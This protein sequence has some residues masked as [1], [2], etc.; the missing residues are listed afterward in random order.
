MTDTEKTHPCTLSSKGVA[1][2][3]YC[4]AMNRQTNTHLTCCVKAACTSPWRFCPVCIVERRSPIHT[5]QEGGV[6]RAHGAVGTLNKKEII[7][8]REKVSRVTEEEPKPAIPV[9][10]P[11][12]LVKAKEKSEIQETARRTVHHRVTP[13]SLSRR[14][15]RVME[16]RLN[17]KKRR[18]KHLGKRLTRYRT[19]P[20]KVAFKL[21]STWDYTIA[22]VEH[23]MRDMPKDPP[24]SLWQV[25]HRATEYLNIGPHG[26]YLRLAQ[27]LT[28]TDLEHMGIREKRAPR[29]VLP[30][31]I[32]D[33]DFPRFD[34]EF[35]E[36]CRAA[37]MRMG[38]YRPE[39]PE[40]V[41]RAFT[42][43]PRN[44]WADW[45]TIVD[46]LDVAYALQH[47]CVDGK[48]GVEEVGKFFG[49]Q[50][51]WVE[52]VLKLH[53]L[54]PTIRGFIGPKASPDW[55]LQFGQ[56][57]LVSS[58]KPSE[59]L[60]ATREEMWRVARSKYKL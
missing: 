40:K 56:A 60:S 17:E 45:D 48:M 9:R 50:G 34:R 47:F 32:P 33:F 13:E 18:L 57:V 36:E 35:D 28:D 42:A 41:L 6:C 11:R 59:Q 21:F 30:K 7:S 3:Q 52:I 2:E 5:L 14:L 43:I 39:E 20:E 54:T 29:E 49:R 22:A 58:K 4:R 26:L 53:K 8:R 38:A 10:V 25:A 1:T 46:P 19:T 44:S 23:V 37:L 15:A 27:G 55:R 24:P 31:R 51:Y 16:M 12:I